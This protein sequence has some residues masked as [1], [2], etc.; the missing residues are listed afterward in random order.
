MRTFCDVTANQCGS[1]LAK[2][3]AFEAKAFAIT[4]G[5]IDV[6]IWPITRC[7]GVQDATADSAFE[8]AFV[9]NSAFGEYLVGVVDEAA[10]FG[11]ALAF[12]SLE[13]FR[14]V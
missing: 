5:A 4:A 3:V 6:V 12:G 1:T 2:S 10:A 7:S 9:V 8:T 11:T 14:L 13:A